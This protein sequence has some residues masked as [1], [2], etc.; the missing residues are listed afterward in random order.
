MTNAN[1]AVSGNGGEISIGVAS[2][3]L[4]FVIWRIGFGLLRDCLVSQ[5]QMIA[6]GQRPFCFN[7]SMAESRTL[8]SVSAA[9]C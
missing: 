2:W 1:Q 7:V 4:S 8:R 5:G 6:D 3:S 9:N